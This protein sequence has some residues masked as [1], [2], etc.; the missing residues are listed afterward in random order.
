MGWNWQL[1]ADISPLASLQDLEILDLWWNPSVSSVAV[2]AS[3]RKL[4][5]LDISRTNIQDISCLPESLEVLDISWTQIADLGSIGRLKRLHKLRAKN[6]FRVVDFRSIGELARL[7][8]LDLSENNLGDSSKFLGGLHELEYLGLRKSHAE[9]LELVLADLRN[10]K[11]L[12]LRDATITDLEFVK[13]L[14]KLEQISI[15]HNA[16]EIAHIHK[17]LRSLKKLEIIH[18]TPEIKELEN[19]PAE[20]ATKLTAAYVFLRLPFENN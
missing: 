4:K 3:L 8:F 11:G 15:G 7:N 17:G 19:F 5:Y 6:L 12:S 14:E 18:V 16:L 2:L 13:N 20:L 9:N 10:L 1:S